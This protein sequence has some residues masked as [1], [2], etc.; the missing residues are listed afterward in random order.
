MSG[1]KGGRNGVGE[2]GKVVAWGKVLSLQNTNHPV[3]QLEPLGLKSQTGKA[4]RRQGRG[5]G[6]GHRPPGNK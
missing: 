3:G 2:G 1:G 5:P 6:M 4:G